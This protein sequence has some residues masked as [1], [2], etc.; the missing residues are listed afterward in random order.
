M[1][2]NE[3]LAH[4]KWECKVPCGLDPQVPAQGPVRGAPQAPRPGAAG[5]STAARVCGGG[6]PSQP[7]PCTHAAVHPAEICGGAGPRVH[8]GEERH[9]HCPDLPRAAAELHGPALLGPRILCVH[10]GP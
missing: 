9:P 1:D 8:Q 2:D 6:G 4:A 7:R 3:S 5:V 10:R